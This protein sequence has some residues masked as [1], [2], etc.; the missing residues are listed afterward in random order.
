MSNETLKS[1]L[2]ERQ[3]QAAASISRRIASIDD[4]GLGTERPRL[5]EDTWPSTGRQLWQQAGTI[6][7][8]K[9]YHQVPNRKGNPISPP[10]WLS[11]ERE[12]NT[13][14][15]GGDE[16]NHSDQWRQPRAGD[17]N[18]QQGRHHPW[19]SKTGKTTW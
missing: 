18:K 13:T 5:N 8:P 15:E 2:S 4:H 10:W 9:N 12:P 17:A 14:L 7:R 3:L 11:S 1:F 16:W 19:K 6:W